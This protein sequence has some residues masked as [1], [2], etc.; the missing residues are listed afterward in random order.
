MSTISSPE[1]PYCKKSE[2]VKPIL[3]MCHAYKEYSE[4]KYKCDNCRREFAVEYY[5]N[6]KEYNRKCYKQFI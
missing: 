5:G 3:Y 4:M 6:G 2:D 1:C